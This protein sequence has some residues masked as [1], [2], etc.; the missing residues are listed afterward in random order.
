MPASTVRSAHRRAG[1]DRRLPSCAIRPAARWEAAAS[2]PPPAAA[3][4][5]ATGRAPPVSGPIGQEPVS[6]PAGPRDDGVSAGS[7]ISS[8]PAPSDT[9]GPV[10]CTCLA[11]PRGLR[12]VACASPLPGRPGQEGEVRHT[13]PIPAGPRP[14]PP[15][16]EAWPGHHRPRSTRGFRRARHL[17]SLG[18]NHP[19][20][21]PVPG[22]M[23]AADPLESGRAGGFPCRGSPLNQV[24]ETGS[25]IRHRAFPHE[26]RCKP[27]KAS[28]AARTSPCAGQPL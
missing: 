1:A 13:G 10:P 25:R 4:A 17:Q 18:T 21:N 23:A 5:G 3:P 14:A 20:A 9:R 28:G 8:A 16:H 26:T 11:R 24:Y 7:R 2:V 12:P 22:G 6:R 27:R 19:R 15:S